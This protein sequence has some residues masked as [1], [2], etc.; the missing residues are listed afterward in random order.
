ME[1]AENLY[2]IGVTLLRLIPLAL[3]LI[4]LVSKIYKNKTHLKART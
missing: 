3:K 2:S 1:I 4:Y